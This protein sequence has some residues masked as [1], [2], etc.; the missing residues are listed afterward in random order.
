MAPNAIITVLMRDTER[1]LTRKVD[2]NGMMEA[3]RFEDATLLALKMWEG[4]MNQ[5]RNVTLE[6]GKSKEIYSSPGPPE[7]AQPC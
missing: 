2:S 3:E 1:D 7:G 6:A 5:A 4:V